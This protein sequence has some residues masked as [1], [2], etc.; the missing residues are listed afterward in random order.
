MQVKENVS[1]EVR[2]IKILDSQIKQL[3][4]RNI[5]MVKVL[6][7]LT[8]GDSTWKIEE[9]IRASYANIFLGKLNFLG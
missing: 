8:S 6:L 9:E 1:F 2:Q 5:L 7:D 3:R 4:G